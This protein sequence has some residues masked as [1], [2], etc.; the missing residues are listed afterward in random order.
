MKLFIDG[1]T[2]EV[3]SLAAN[4]KYCNNLQIKVFDRSIEVDNM[5]LY[6]MQNL[7]KPEKE[8]LIPNVI[9]DTDFI[10][11]GEK[12][13]YNKEPTDFQND[14][15]IITTTNPEEAMEWCDCYANFNEIEWQ[16]ITTQ[17]YDEEAKYLQKTL[18]RLDEAKQ[19]HKKVYLPFRYGPYAEESKYDNMFNTKIDKNRLE[20]MKQLANGVYNC[21]SN[22]TDVK[23]VLGT[24]SGSGKFS[25]CLKLKEFYETRYDERTGIIFTENI[26]DL[27]NSDYIEN[28]KLDDSLIINASREWNDLHLEE[29]IEY[30]QYAVAYLETRGCKHILLQGQGTYGINAMNK[31]YIHK[32]NPVMNINNII[33]EHAIGCKSVAIAMCPNQE[34]MLAEYVRYFITR[35][36]ELN[37]VFVNSYDHN[38]EWKHETIEIFNKKIPISPVYNVGEIINEINSVYSINPLINLYTNDVNRQVLLDKSFVRG[39]EYHSYLMETEMERQI[40]KIKGFNIR[41][42]KPGHEKFVKILNQYIDRLKEEI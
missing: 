8:T 15:W 12:V 22:E 3:K 41:F 30:V 14:S 34:H 26:S 40:Y 37:D 17:N 24:C 33:L 28:N 35:G 10:K 36:I 7:I 19:L 31:V 20:Y 38:N 13:F 11:K 1:Y 9:L 16:L 32:N 2:K 18:N 39:D 5:D 6:L 42:G 27:I 29:W 21:Q 25:L 4:I 23:L